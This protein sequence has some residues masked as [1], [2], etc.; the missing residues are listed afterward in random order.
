MPRPTSLPWTEDEEANKLLAEN[1]LALLLGMLLDQQFPMERAFYGPYL[2][3]QR[4]GGKLD[5]A[6]IAAASPE[7]FEA[8]AK[9][10]P[11]IHRFPGSMGKRTQ[12]VCQALVDNWDGD[13]GKLWNTAADGKEL[14][15]RLK[16]L[17]G[18]GDAKARI[19]VAILG[20]HMGVRPPGWEEVAADWPNISDVFSWDDVAELRLKKKE[21]KAAA[22]KG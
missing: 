13:A 5:A 14:L 2:I 15:K 17:P 19:F 21:M 9:G 22:K 7:E 11:A 8:L 6:A 18:Y 1:D 20:R 10:P 3:K 16:A 12:E 4:M